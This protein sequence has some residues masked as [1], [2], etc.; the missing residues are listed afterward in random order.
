MDERRESALSSVLNGGLIDL[1]VLPS[2]PPSLF[3]KKIS[4]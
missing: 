2:F 1:I 3:L 4:L